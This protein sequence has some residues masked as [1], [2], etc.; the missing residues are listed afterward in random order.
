MQLVQES[1]CSRAFRVS[2]DL[3]LG[4]LVSL[5]ANQ[6]LIFATGHTRIAILWLDNGFLPPHM[7]ALIRPP[8]CKSR[9]NDSLPQTTLLCER[10]CCLQRITQKPKFG[11]SADAQYRYCHQF[12][13]WSGCTSRHSAANRAV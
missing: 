7:Q 8:M 12:N 3:S 9:L 11:L 5:D 4:S 2:F 6:F 1:K 10:N 13:V